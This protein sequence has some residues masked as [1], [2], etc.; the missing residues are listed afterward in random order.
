MIKIWTSGAEAGLLDRYG[1]RG[2][3]F[4]YLPATPD[5]RAVSVTMPVRL[6][7]WSL[8]FA[9][10]PVFE[11][12]LPEGFT[13]VNACGWRSRKPQAA[14]TAPRTKPAAAVALLNARSVPAPGRSEQSAGVERP[15]DGGLQSHS[16]VDS[17]RA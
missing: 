9:L 16:R 2:R 15:A 7:S 13:S 10:P 4:A 3:T 1:E 14:S 11:M 5:R 17:I 8:H 12:N 6:P